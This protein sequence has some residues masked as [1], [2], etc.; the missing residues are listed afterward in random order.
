MV[1]KRRK[2]S[3][4]LK[5][6]AKLRRRRLQILVGLIFACIVLVFS[7]TYAVFYRYV[8]R[9]PENKICK[10][11]YIGK[12]DMSGMAEK[13]AKEALEKQTAEDQELVVTIEVEDNR[14]EVPVGEAGLTYNGEA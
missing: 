13:E 7:I 2:R 3:K 5:R 10:N 11:V 12:M 1:Q 9:F 6:A 14:V 8:S 4:S